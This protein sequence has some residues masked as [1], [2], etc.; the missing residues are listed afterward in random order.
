MNLIIFIKVF[1]LLYLSPFCGRDDELVFLRGLKK[2]K[3]V[4][5]C[6]YWHFFIALSR[7]FYGVI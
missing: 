2:L 1:Y 3:S 6:P 4:F 5:I 7:A